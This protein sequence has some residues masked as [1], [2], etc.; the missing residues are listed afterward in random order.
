M[1]SLLKC[2][3][4]SRG[5]LKYFQGSTRLQIF[6]CQHPPLL[7]WLCC[8]S[9]RLFAWLQ[10]HQRTPRLAPLRTLAN[11][12]TFFF[13]VSTWLTPS[14]PSNVCLHLTLTMRPTLSTLSDTVTW[15]LHPWNHHSSN[16]LTSVFFFFP[17]HLGLSSILYNWL[18][19]FVVVSLSSTRVQ[20]LQWSFCLFYFWVYP[21]TIEL[22]LKQSR[23]HQLYVG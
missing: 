3:V 15:L 7:L 18:I 17:W 13:Q 9:P 16:P 19:G 22:C 1:S 21:K 12:G 23:H 2:S 8:S 6:C 14:P 10:P 20:V 4:W 11:P 5:K